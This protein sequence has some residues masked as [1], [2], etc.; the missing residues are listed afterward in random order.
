MILLNNQKKDTKYMKKDSIRVDVIS[1]VACPWCFV[2]KRRLEAALNEWKGIPVEV[3]YFPFQLDP[4]IPKEGLNRDSY[5]H[6]KFRDSEI[7]RDMT[8]RLT[9]VGKSVGIDFDFGENWLAVNTLHLHQLLH[10][11]RLEG[12]ASELKEL[13]FTAYFEETKHLN[14]VETLYEIAKAIGWD[15]QKVDHIISDQTIAEAVQSENSH[16]QQRGVSGVPFYVINNEYGISGAQP[17][18]VFL[19]AFRTVSPIEEIASGEVCDTSSEEC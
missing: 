19:N 7:V 9:E 18:E 3:N 2:G 16:Y 13:L 12:K 1:D 14:R 15:S 11:A 17:S 10:V 5:L 6:N 4:S 8:I